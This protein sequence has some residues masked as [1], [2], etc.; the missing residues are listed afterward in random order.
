[1]TGSD[2]EF[3]G[4]LAAAGFIPKRL[5]APRCGWRAGHPVST[6]I[7]TAVRVVG[8]IHNYAPNCRPNSFMAGAAGFTDLYILVLF[9]AD[10]S[11]GSHAVGINHADFAAW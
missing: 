4:S 3:S 5:L 11:Y 2:N 1:M 9:V 10:N 8:G 6:T 7:A